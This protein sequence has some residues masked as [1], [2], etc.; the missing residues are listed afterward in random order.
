MQEEAAAETQRRKERLRVKVI[1]IGCGK[2]GITISEYLNRQNHDVTVVDNNS[3]AFHSFNEDFTGKMVCGFGYDREVLEQAGITVADVLISCANNDSMNAVIASVAKN[4][5]H[6]PTVIARMYDPVRARMFE[7]MGI[8]ALSVTRLEVENIVEYLEDN[9]NWR[10]V[11]KLSNEDIQIVKARVSSG[12]EG[13]PVSE[14]TVDDKIRLIA[15]E[16]HGNALFPQPDMVCE[17]NDMLY[18]AVRRDCILKA[19][20]LLKL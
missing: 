11:R 8:Y 10:V 14:L 18:L 1:V 17:Y 3:E 2:F 13:T 6:V 9:K 5:Y 19:R 16:R 7:A 20:E 4:I 15:L 12:L